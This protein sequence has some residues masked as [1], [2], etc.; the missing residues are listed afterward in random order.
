MAVIEEGTEFVV[1]DLIFKGDDYTL[2]HENVALTISE[3]CKE[4]LEE[5]PDIISFA[6]PLILK[7]CFDCN[8]LDETPE[9]GDPH[10]RIVVYAERK[11]GSSVPSS[12]FT[13]PGYKTPK[14]IVDDFLRSDT[15]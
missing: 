4:M 12:F 5:F 6:D 7:R 8:H 3:T 13:P 10:Y 9:L 15:D 1:C 2:R 11:E 14:E